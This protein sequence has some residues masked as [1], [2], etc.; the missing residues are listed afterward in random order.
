MK[1]F[2][3]ALL[4]CYLVDP[5]IAVD[6]CTDFCSK[7]LGKP[8]DTLCVDEDFC[9]TLMWKTPEKTEVCQFEGEKSCPD[10]LPV[11]CNEAEWLLSA[12]EILSASS[13]NR[14]AQ[15]HN[16]K[17]ES[18]PA[19]KAA[20]TVIIIGAG[21]SGA[22]AANALVAAGYKVTIVEARNRI[23]GRT[24]TDRKSLSKPVDL[25]AGWIHEADGNPITDLCK[26]YKIAITPTDYENA[27]LYDQ[28]GE[29]VSEADSAAS[30]KIF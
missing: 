13:H 10:T 12:G 5:A 26:K 15:A 16:K 7:Y 6:S 8:C 20:P 23:G 22:S 3:T 17:P 29:S 24:W 9:Q 27:V 28:D 2:T 4:A 19:K 30:D 18:K 25:G 21:M 11:K 1:K 14:H